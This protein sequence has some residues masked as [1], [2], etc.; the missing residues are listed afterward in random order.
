MSSWVPAK[1]ISRSR[2]ASKSRSP[3]KTVLAE[4]LD[5]YMWTPIPPTWR[6]LTKIREKNIQSMT[7]SKI[8]NV[9]DPNA[10]F[11]L[12][13]NMKKGDY[14]DTYTTQITSE[15]WTKIKSLTKKLKGG[16]AKNKRR[17]QHKTT[18]R[19]R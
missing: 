10:K 3:S 9:L 11:L 13:I 4:M 19:K 6:P 5:D 18:Q 1:S 16:T 8:G 17:A 7:A 14:T 15:D 12:K 2:S